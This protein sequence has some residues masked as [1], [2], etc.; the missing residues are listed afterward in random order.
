MSRF[1]LVHGSWHGGWCFRW[2]AHELKNRAHEVAAPY[3]PCEE[4]GLTPL[5]YARAVGRQ[6][7]AIV[8]GHA[9]AGRTLPPRTLR[10]IP[11][12]YRLLASYLC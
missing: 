2:L 9:L 10:R 5:D 3:L 6:P 11:I 12:G 8:V 1:V 7:D 4:V